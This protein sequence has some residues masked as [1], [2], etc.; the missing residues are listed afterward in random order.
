MSRTIDIE[1]LKNQA[2]DSQS[3]QGLSKIVQ[4]RNR[5]LKNNEFIKS[6][7]LFAVNLRGYK[8]WL[9]EC[10]AFSTIE[11]Y[12]EIFRRKNHFLVPGFSGASASI[13]VDIGT[14]EGFYLLK[15]KENN[16]A[17]KVIAVEPSPYSF[18]L[19]EK[20]VHANNMENVI[21]INKAVGQEATMTTFEC[22]KEIG[23]I[24]GKGL[25]MIKRPWL[26]D[27]YIEQKQI[28]M[29]PLEQILH[30]HGIEKVDIL[31]IDVEGMELDVLQ[32][33]QGCLD[34][35]DRIVVERHSRKLRNDIVMF[36]SKCGFNLIY[37]EDPS[38]KYYYGDLYFINQHIDTI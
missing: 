19:L 29:V 21:L 20:N 13:V 28:D 5:I 1:W 37:E 17:C 35:I 7:H 24:S 6:D 27:D 15:I 22:V 16:P 25:R 4:L 3:R 36:L 11:I 33:G 38:F 12:E 18:S 10:S 26:N 32:G 8:I 23:A 9:R 31:K 2:V 34:R 30:D 14:H